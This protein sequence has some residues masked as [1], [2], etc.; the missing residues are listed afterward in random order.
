MTGGNQLAPPV[1][2]PQSTSR[3]DRWSE[4]N[5]SGETRRVPVPWGIQ[6]DSARKPAGR[7]VAGNRSLQETRRLYQAIMRQAVETYQIPRRGV[8][9]SE[10][11]EPS[12]QVRNMGRSGRKKQQPDGSAVEDSHTV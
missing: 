12:A 2:L 5:E 8:D 1:K 4:S 6:S 3:N 10:L 11:V 7:Q 9:V